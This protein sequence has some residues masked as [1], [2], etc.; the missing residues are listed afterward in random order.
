MAEVLYDYDFDD[1]TRLGAYDN[2]FHPNSELKYTYE[3]YAGWDLPPRERYELYKGAPMAMASAHWR[4][5][6]VQ[7]NIFGVLFV[8]LK[9][10]PCTPLT[11]LDVR[12]FPRADKK[13][14]TV[15]QPDII[16][17]CDKKKLGGLGGH[18]C[19]GVP[20]LILEILSP[21]TRRNDLLY[22]LNL[23]EEAGV[24]EYWIVD[25]ELKTVQQYILQSNG[26]LARTFGEGEINVHIFDGALKIALSDI[27]EGADE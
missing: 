13:D 14:M 2:Y 21:S 6:T 3:D 16:V 23:Y 1:G 12:L 24:R 8:F 17:V 11:D 10:K 19:D 26:Y 9:G 18:G 7:A 22:K 5:Q 27:F 25:P 15:V 20:D 4:H